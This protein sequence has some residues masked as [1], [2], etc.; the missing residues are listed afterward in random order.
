MG[1]ALT[2][3]Q[4]GANLV[5]PLSK[6]MPSVASGVVE[7]RLRDSAGIYRVFYFKKSV[8]GILVFH[9]FIKKSQKTSLSEIALGKKRLLEVF[10]EEV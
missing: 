5:M 7:L 6:S 4:K 3:L 2:D 10:N 1:K 9:A 8:K